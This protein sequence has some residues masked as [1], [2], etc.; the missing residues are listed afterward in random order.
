VPPGACLRIH[1]AATALHMLPSLLRVPDAARAVAP[2]R[3]QRLRPHRTARG[4]AA[5]G[6][7]AAGKRHRRTAMPPRHHTY[8]LLDLVQSQQKQKAYCAIEIPSRYCSS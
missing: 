7:A 6:R 8:T 3:P 5:A 2:L 4:P 1:C